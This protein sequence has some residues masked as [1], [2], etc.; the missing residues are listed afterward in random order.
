MPPRSNE[1]VMRLDTAPGLDCETVARRRDPGDSATGPA[2]Y[3]VTHVSSVHYTYDTRILIKE[4]S[5]TA[6]AGYR[7]VFVSPLGRDELTPAGVQ[8]R[9]AGIPRLT[10]RFGRW[11][12]TVPRVIRAAMHERPDIVHLHDPE[13]IIPGMILRL[14]GYRVIYDVHEHVP[15]AIMTKPYIPRP[16]RRLIAAL[17][18]GFEALAGRVMSGIVAT[19]EPIAARFPAH[20]TV[21]VDNWVIAEEFRASQS[22][23]PYADRS[24]RLVYIG[25]I[26]R[27]RG[28]MQ[29]L[30]AMTL[31]ADKHDVRL[32]LGGNIADKALEEDMRAHPMW[33]RVDYKGFMD[34]PTMAEAFSQSRVGLVVYLP[35]PNN[36]VT[37]ANKVFENMAA[38]LPV[39]ASDFRT[40]N[41]V[42]LGTGC[43]LTV[44][45]TDPRAIADAIDRL[46]NDPE[47]AAEMG[48]RGAE[49]VDTHFSWEHE[50]EK[51]LALYARL[52][53]GERARTGA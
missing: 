44:D 4:C 15:R 23:V 8:I 27:A 31:L 49:A 48:R 43:G 40:R 26:A 51:L 11:F 24:K 35:T 41:D 29:I 20:K 32:T 21:L 16:L 25:V 37:S 47:Q 13:L 7:T 14:L 45:P 10:G 17:A 12:L 53:A 28:I 36:M 30:D 50:A 9:G 3:C 22:R 19:S 5:S 34:R 1:A 6:A 2:N 18:A 38:G 52:I 42:I 46:F 39:V 33:R